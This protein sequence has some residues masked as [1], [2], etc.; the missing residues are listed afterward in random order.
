MS[1]NKYL[2]DL[3]VVNPPLILCRKAG[4]GNCSCG[5]ATRPGSF[6]WW[7]LQHCPPCSG[8]GFCAAARKTNKGM[9][10]RGG[11]GT[12]RGQAQPFTSNPFSS[13]PCSVPN[14]P[15]LNIFFWGCCLLSCYTTV[16]YL[17]L[18]FLCLACTSLWPLQ[19]KDFL[20]AEIYH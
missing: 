9:G 17:I 4:T 6:P 19:L 18:I 20:S 15:Y 14:N 7:L 2:C 5:K 10:W 11:W 12:R 8:T 1:V 3:G 13:L 16:L